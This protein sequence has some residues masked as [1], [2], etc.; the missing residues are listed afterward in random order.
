MN[1]TPTHRI[2]TLEVNKKRIGIYISGRLLSTKHVCAFLKFTK[3]H[4]NWPSHWPLWRSIRVCVCL[5]ANCYSDSCVNNKNLTER[6]SK[7]KVSFFLL[8]FLY[9]HSQRAR[10]R[11][12]RRSKYLNIFYLCTE[13]VWW[14]LDDEHWHWNG[15][16]SSQ[17]IQKCRKT[18]FVSV[19]VI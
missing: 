9:R 8:S 1:T 4:N 18:I 10:E 6:L 11:E 3:L 13:I 2:F 14:I 12:R 15:S 17:V 7:R 16:S 5:F 19:S